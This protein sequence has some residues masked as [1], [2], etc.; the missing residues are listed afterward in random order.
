MKVQAEI[1]HDLNSHA[2]KA[3]AR[4]HVSAETCTTAGSL[5]ILTERENREGKNT[6]YQE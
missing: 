5:L 4:S 1:N 3:E 6:E 2:Q